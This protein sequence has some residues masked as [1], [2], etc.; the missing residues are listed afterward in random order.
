MTDRPLHRTRNGQ[1]PGSGTARP[2]LGRRGFAAAAGA[3]LAAPLTLG[4]LDAAHAGVVPAGQ[5][6]GGGHG[7]GHGHPGHDEDRRTLP[8]GDGWG[9]AEGGTTGGAHAHRRHVYDV[10]SRSELVEALADAGDAASIVRVHGEIQFNVDEN[11]EPVTAEKLAEG[12]GYT[13][14]KYLAAY[15]PE[16]WGRDKVPEGEQEEARKAAALTQRD[17]V[18]VKVPSRTTIIGVGPD[19]KLVGASLQVSGVDNV[20]IRNLTIADTYDLFPQWDPTDGDD[21]NWNSEYDS[22]R[23]V[24]D[25]THVWVD[26]CAFTDEPMTDDQLPEHFGREYQRHDGAL[27]ITN[28]SDFVTVSWNRFSD[29]DKLTLVGSTDDPDKGDPG[30]LRVT[31]HHN[32]YDG[33]GQR[34]PRARFGHVDVYNNHYLISDDQKVGYGYSIAIGV[35]SHV[36]AEA[37]AFDIDGDIPASTILSHANGEVVTT[38]GNLV[39]G[40]RVDLRRVYNRAAD[41]DKQ[42]ARDTSWRPHLRRRVDP[43]RRVAHVVDRGAGPR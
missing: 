5:G 28:R 27:D 15:D 35:D 25:T 8:R 33:V 22:I 2:V 39:N 9:S 29:H 30:T 7:G 23:I 6:H 43:A 19:A 4:A 32:L 21:G 11:D 1:T 42:L 18:Q 10:G 20:I 12:T 36:W 16:V 13:L 34:A 38:R 41:G 37:N 26:H 3:V 14:E 24:D 31:F 40:R 17:L